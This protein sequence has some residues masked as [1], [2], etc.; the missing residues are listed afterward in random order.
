[1]IECLFV[2]AL[3]I[4]V[5]KAS[6]HTGKNTGVGQKKAGP[7]NLQILHFSST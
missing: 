7:R 6:Q 4:L 2:D 3:C 5:K 1:M